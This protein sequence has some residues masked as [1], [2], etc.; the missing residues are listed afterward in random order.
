MS[1]WSSFNLQ[2]DQ[3]I[4]ER[5][6]QKNRRKSVRTEHK[7]CNKVTY[8]A[9]ESFLF[10]SNEHVSISLGHDDAEKSLSLF[11]HDETRQDKDQGLRIKG[12][13][14]WCDGYDDVYVCHGSKKIRV[15]C[16]TRDLGP[17][18]VRN[19]VELISSSS[20][21]LLSQASSLGS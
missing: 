17:T 7:T 15:C 16:E 5:S 4:K 12:Q 2:R 3:R 18:F 10:Q 21:W 14:P 19:S 9:S 1:K 11:L 13:V 20:W 6:R 8:T